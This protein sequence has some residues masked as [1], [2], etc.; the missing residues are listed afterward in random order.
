M[1]GPNDRSTSGGNLNLL[2]RPKLEPR[3]KPVSQENG[4]HSMLLALSDAS[5]KRDAS[6]W[7]AS[8]VSETGV[9]GTV[10]RVRLEPRGFEPPQMSGQ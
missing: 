7:H 4:R 5:F 8:W 2:L 9:R 10:F 3:S 6:C 1:P